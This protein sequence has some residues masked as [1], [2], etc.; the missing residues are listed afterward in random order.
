M[1]PNDETISP[2]EPDPDPAL[3]S[4]EASSTQSAA[5]CAVEPPIHKRP[6]WYTL[7]RISPAILFTV[8]YAVLEH[9]YYVG[10]R[11]A[12]NSL[13]NSLYLLPL[14]FIGSVVVAVLSA[15]GGARPS[16][17][18]RRCSSGWFVPLGHG[19]Q[20]LPLV[21]RCLVVLKTMSP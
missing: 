18:R 7:V 8:A 5:G 3:G 12:L 15:L 14:G 13:A 4:A 17:H 10:G 6:G 21:R 1:N 16:T 11:D 9:R 20:C 19:A 2:H